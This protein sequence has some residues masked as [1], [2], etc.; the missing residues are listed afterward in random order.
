MS[1]SPYAMYAAG[2]TRTKVNKV[3]RNDGKGMM[4]RNILNISRGAVRR[5]DW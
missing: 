3:R 1:E 2:T 5:A 4:E